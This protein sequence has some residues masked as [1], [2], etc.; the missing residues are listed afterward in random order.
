MKTAKQ[1]PFKFLD[2]YQREDS[3]WFFGRDE[4]IEAL[5][6]MVF[7]STVVLVYGASG[8]GKTSLINCGL[9]GKF[10]PHD[11]F[12]IMVRRGNDLNASLESELKKSGGSFES[13][14]F[15][16]AWEDE[17]SESSTT[18]STE[19]SRVGNALR[20]I[21]QKSFRPIYL[22]FDQFEELFVLGTKKEQ[23]EFFKTTLD[24]LKS[25]QPVKILFSIREEYLGF[26]Y[27]FEKV[28]PQ[29]LKKKLR[30]EPMN[31]EKVKQVVIGA[32]TAPNS[33]ISIKSGDENGV[34]EGVFEKIKGQ[35]K[36]LTIQ[37]PFLQVFL[38]KY[39]LTITSDE[40]RTTEAQFST[41]NLSKMGEIGDI[42]IELLEEQVTSVSNI[43]KVDFPEVN[44]ELIW[45]ILSPFSTLEGTKEP[46]SKKE[47]KNRLPDVSTKITDAVIEAFINSRILRYIESSDLYEIAHDA[48]AKPIAE[49]RTAEETTLLEIKRLIKSQVSINEEAREFFS[50]KQLAFI[51]PFLQKI[52]LTEEE[53][54]W[55]NKSS[56]HFEAI[57]EQEI[58][59]KINESK[60]KRRR[61]L[62]RVGYVVLIVFALIIYAFYSAGLSIEVAQSKQKII[63]MQEHSDQLLKLMMQGRGPQ[64]DS[65]GT[66]EMYNKLDQELTMP[67]EELIIPRA[68]ITQVNDSSHFRNITIWIEVPPHRKHE[69]SSVT[70]TF[71][72]QAKDAV[73]TTSEP[74]S[75]FAI[76]Y[77]G[78]FVCKKMQYEITLKDGDPILKEFSFVEFL[79]DNKENIVDVQPEDE[80]GVLIFN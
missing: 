50:E 69:I 34:A 13:A 12:P 24:I 73:R 61:R 75:S 19:L 39:Y 41:D 20:S 32:G 15:D 37:L 68:H 78:G 21:Y 74:T 57:R 28:V 23:Q 45:K 6:E 18:P 7:Q 9:A 30:V 42:L 14:N 48:L 22:I 5:Y 52:N 70:Y 53:K 54:D 17:F 10:Q 11:W 51:D 26:L 66:P 46:I 77:L 60:K 8:T 64:Y 38:D 40:S 44:P 55:V 47:L 43:L 3:E 65:I 58:Q 56:A 72:S 1:Y 71:C 59:D 36:S 33:N 67:L 80:N 25:N 49:R 2:S 31:L 79:K 27:E 29:L 62:K 63:Q 76:G 16:F 4:E 35:A